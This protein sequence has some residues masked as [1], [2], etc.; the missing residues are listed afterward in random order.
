[1]ET[2]KISKLENSQNYKE[3]KI[4]TLPTPLTTHTK[5]IGTAMYSSPE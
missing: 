1:M 4:D 5:N 2:L 3:H